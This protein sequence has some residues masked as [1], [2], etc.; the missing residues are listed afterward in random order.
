MESKLAGLID[1]LE[2][3]VQRAEASSGGSMAQPAQA[4]GPQAPLVK[5]W[6]DDVVS[7]LKPFL[8]ATKTLGV[9]QVSTAAD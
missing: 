3:V 6:Q 7:K 2:K 4:A 8:D 5:M 1:R 9:A